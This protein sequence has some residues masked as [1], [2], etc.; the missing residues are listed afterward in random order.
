M[1]L[2]AAYSELVTR[3]KRPHLL[4]SIGELLGWDEQVNLPAA[5]ADQR[6]QQHAVLADVTHA[7]ASDP[8]IGEL[9]AVLE[10]AADPAARPEVGPYLAST[11]LEII[12][13]TG[14]SLRVLHCCIGGSSIF[15][16]IS[17]PRIFTEIAEEAEGNTVYGLSLLPPLPPVRRF[18]FGCGSPRY[19]F[20][21]PFRSVL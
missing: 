20:L 7:A 3:I 4:G 9:L 13:N 16:R 18:A 6:A 14:S 19:A 5:S 10:K 8:R 17:D 2:E 15:A 12:D 21:R 11:L 1:T